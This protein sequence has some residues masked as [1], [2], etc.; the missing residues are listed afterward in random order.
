MYHK[1]FVNNLKIHIC[2]A[3]CTHACMFIINYRLTVAMVVCSLSETTEDLYPQ[4][5]SLAT[6]FVNNPS[7]YICIVDLRPRQDR[8]TK[9]T[10]RQSSVSSYPSYTICTKPVH[11]DYYKVHDIVNFIEV[12]RLF[13]AE[14]FIFYADAKTANL[15]NIRCLESYSK[16][17]IV[18]L[19]PFT[20]P[21]L[22]SLRRHGQMITIT[23]CMYRAM[24]RT[25]FVVNV[26][27]DEFIVP[28]K[29]D[30]WY[31]MVANLHDKTNHPD[32]I[33]AY[34]FRNQFFPLQKPDD[35]YFENSAT[36]KRYYITALLKTLKE[37]LIFPSN[38]KS[39]IMGRPERILVWNTHRILT[40]YLVYRDDIVWYVHPD[41]ALLYHY[42]R[43]RSPSSNRTIR[44]R[45]MHAFSSQLID[46]V[47]TGTE[48][49]LA[50][51]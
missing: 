38:R 19:Y 20:P 32:N 12:N 45:R 21:V 7:N 30:N 42:R 28:I 51:E 1:Y 6:E 46:N 25:K 16:L 35:P 47:R 37:D 23:D 8:F 9:E 48:R 50:P 17:G 33:A 2:I 40:D 5:V 43:W 26:D 34:S 36:A 10:S 11:D 39:K 13:G 29:D 15:S 44:E 49:C 27:L 41:D 22:D 4:A 18:E 31:Q 24:Y 14:K 3:Y